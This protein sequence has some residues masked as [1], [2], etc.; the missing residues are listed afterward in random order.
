[1]RLK[2]NE[3]ITSDL[4]GYHIFID[5][6]VKKTNRTWVITGMR[7][8]EIGFQCGSMPFS[9]EFLIENCQLFH[10]DINPEMFL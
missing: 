6:K 7:K 5:E 2:T 8:T 9:A 3:E 1:M 10:P 4:I